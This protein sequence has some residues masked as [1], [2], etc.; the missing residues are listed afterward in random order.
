MKTS[1]ITSNFFIPHE[2][3]CGLQCKGA[4]QSTLIHLLLYSN[5][6]HS[7]VVDDLVYM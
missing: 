4:V 6:H 1:M 3:Q 5:F 7:K 2:E